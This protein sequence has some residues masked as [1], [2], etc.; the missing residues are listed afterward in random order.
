MIKL[1]T[2]IGTRPQIIKS[3]AIS[4]AIRTSFSNEINEVIVHTGQ[5]YD[6]NMSDIFFEEL[7]I[8]KPKYNLKVGSLSHANQTAAMLIGIEEI[9]LNEKPNAILVYGD[10]NSTI[11]GAIA[12]SKINI[13]IIHVEAGLRSNNKAMPEEI[14]RIVTD[15][16]STMLFCPTK[17][18]IKNLI[19]EGFKVGDSYNEKASIDKPHTYFCGDIMYDNT[20]Y[21]SQIS[22]KE[23]HL[24]EKHNIDKN[25]YILATIHRP[26]N[27]DDAARLQDIFESFIELANKHNI[28]IVLPLHPRTAAI[29]EK[30]LP[31]NIFA[32]IKKNEK[33]IL[34][35]PLSFLQ[36]LLFEK[37]A[38]LILTDSGG[39]QKE[40]YFLNKYSIVLRTETEWIEIVEQG[41]A[42][43]TDTQ[44]RLILDAADKFLKIENV[45][46]PKLFGDGKS[47]E[48]ICQKIIENFY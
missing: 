17:T 3:A 9:L 40:A 14:N 43:T 8:S 22:E 23:N 37:N 34:L 35:E 16:T 7:Q 36:M 12:A 24:F 13:P 33:I 29:L 27:T 45:Q 42:K 38:K 11:A 6:V 15:H 30:S 26:S 44:Q 4:R 41:A 48:F 2:I 5:H 28:T 1:I 46:F 39:V 18:A 31:E 20:L 10:T 32:E 21:F 19:N 25:N 47:A